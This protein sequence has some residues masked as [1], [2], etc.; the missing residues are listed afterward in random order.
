MTKSVPLFFLILLITSLQIFGQ[1][2]ADT[3]SNEESKTEIKGIVLDEAKQTALPY[4]N[5]YVLN[6]NKGTITNEKG[7][8]TLNISDL[9]GN[10]TVR[11]QYI[12]YKIK[13]LTV[14]ELISSGNVYL[15]EEIINLSELIVFGEVPDLKTIVKN[16][17][18][19]KDSNYREITSKRQFFLR[20]RDI[21]DFNK[22]N[23]N[24]KKSTID[25]LDRNMIQTIEDKMPDFV[26]SFTDFLGY[27]Y[28]N[29]NKDDSVKQKLDP[30]RMVS[31]KE[32]YIED[33]KNLETI[34]EGIFSETN[35]DEYWKVRSGIFGSKL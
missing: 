5:I 14:D 27:Y 20:D 9:N 31:L 19:Y 8:F 34:F 22:F 30:I 3:L 16:V 10:D 7:H 33:L 12:G 18:L 2:L 32:E 25:E 23:L 26:T 1:G 21:A 28:S 6:N 13:L 35:D 17:L 11:F 15:S 4:T 29:K 24:Y